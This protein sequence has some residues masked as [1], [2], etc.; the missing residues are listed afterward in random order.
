MTTSTAERM[1][2]WV[3]ENALRPVA[4][5]IIFVL[6]ALLWT[7]PLQ[8]VIAYPFVFLFFGAVMGSAW[9]GGMV[10]GFVAVALSSLLVGYFFIPPL[11]SMTIAK[12]SQSFF[13]AFILCAIAITVVSSARKRAET[14]VRTA[15]DELEERVKERTAE[16]EQSNREIQ[17]SERQLRQLTEAI[18]Q[19]IWRADASGNVE[20]LN[21]HLLAYLGL[22]AEL[23]QGESFFHVFHADDEPLIRQ[24]WRTALQSK[25]TFEAEAR[26]GSSQG[27]YRWFL[28]RAVPQMDGDGAVARWYG[29]HIDIEE[30]RQAQQSLA[31]AQEEQS[32]ISHLLSLAEMAASIAHELNQPLTAVRR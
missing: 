18:P 9:F 29:I 23:L 6:V 20:Y 25:N 27:S 28:V 4:F 1:P 24:A 15:R 32:R 17:E 3:I 12:G 13:T 16:L 5:A 19:Q 21:G 7:F 2:A 14:V 11:Y 26:V 22:R 10:A 30:Q 31:D 8:H